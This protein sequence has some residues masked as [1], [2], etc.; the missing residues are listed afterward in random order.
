MNISIERA[1]KCLRLHHIN[2]MEYHGT[3][4]YLEE[5]T[6]TID[7]ITTPHEAWRKVSKLD[8]MDKM[9]EFLNY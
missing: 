7:E 3:W 4:Y 6:E 5:W 1:L 8:T 9:K 2:V